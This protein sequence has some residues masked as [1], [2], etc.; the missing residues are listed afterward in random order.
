[1]W[2]PAQQTTQLHC[3]QQQQYLVPVPPPF[4]VPLQQ[5]PTADTHTINICRHYLRGQCR[6]GPRCRFHHPSELEAIMITGSAQSSSLLNV[7]PSSTAVPATLD[8]SGSSSRICKYFLHGVACPYKDQCHFIHS[9]QDCIDLPVRN[10]LL[11][12]TPNT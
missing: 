7:T 1:M 6:W 4:P 10:M 11:D 8:I 2:M 12:V 9:L 3:Q 5:Q